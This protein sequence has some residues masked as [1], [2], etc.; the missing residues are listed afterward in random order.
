MSGARSSSVSTATKLRARYLSHLVSILDRVR[1]SP[2]LRAKPAA[3]RVPGSFRGVKREKREA[4]HSPPSSVEVM[5]DGVIPPL[6]SLKWCLIISA[7]EQLQLYLE[8]V[9]E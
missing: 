2:V 5:N 8:V 9:C 1:F 6:P 4:D 7:E 3:K